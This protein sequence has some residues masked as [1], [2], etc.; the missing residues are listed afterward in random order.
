MSP[1]AAALRSWLGTAGLPSS[2]G[3]EDAAQQLRAAAPEVYE[4]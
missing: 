4:D 3:S 2:P 1:D